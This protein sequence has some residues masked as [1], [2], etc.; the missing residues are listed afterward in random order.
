[1]MTALAHRG[2]DD[3]GFHADERAVLGNRRLEVIDLEGGRQPL[4]NEDESLWI[5][6]NGEIYNY[7][8]LRRDL[9]RAGHRFRTHTD[10]EV[11]LHLYE[12]LGEGCLER[13]RG[14]FAF[15]IWDR[16]RDRLFAARDRFGQKP[17]FYSVVGDRLL[18]ASEIKGLLAAGIAPDPEPA[19]VDYYLTFRFVPP[20][21]TMFRA[22]R[23]LAAGH[24]LTWS[25]G[26]LR[27]E[28]WWNFEYRE[29]RSRSD[30][31]WL[32]E[33]AERI[34]D[35]VAS[36]LVSDVPVGALLS[37]GLDSSLVALLAARAT[38]RPLP[39]FTI[40][41]EVASYDERPFA[42]LVAAHCR[43]DHHSRVVSQE[44]LT[45][46]P[47]LV[48]YLDEP[49][50]P[51]SA[52]FLESARLA[53]EHVKV[54]LGG[55]GGDELFAGFDRYAA[56]RW[57]DW[58]GRLPPP[59]RDGV[60]RP[61][62]DRLPESFTYKGM[63]QRA[64][65]ALDVGAET[66]AARYA[67]MN[68]FFRF[69]RRERAELYGPEL[70]RALNGHDAEEAITAPFAEVASLHTLH[71][72]LRTDIL[73]KL[74][75]HTMMLSDRL[76]MACG[77]ELRSPL[78]DHELAEL[79]AAMPVRLKV[80]R[81][82]SKWALRRIARGRLPDRI[83]ERPK[84]GFMFPVS[85]WLN[86]GTVPALRASLARGSLVTDGWIRQETVDRLFDE[87]LRRRSDHHVRIWMLLSLQA[88]R[89]LHVDGSGE[90]ARLR[91]AAAPPPRE[92]AESRWRTDPS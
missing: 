6:F 62:V 55:D 33:L 26:E 86:T 75:E 46:I 25:Q 82:R 35:A 17:L 16:A 32:A 51:I 73:T 18:F 68:S 36:H 3:E 23:K 92:P 42:D 24:Y 5:T 11:V 76:S 43:S 83:V 78:L 72:M 56:W 14:M 21:L 81:G 7:R 90:E 44:Q 66:G 2:P 60:I 54:A 40:G 89:T 10:T 52:C 53:S 91:Q 20:P 48:R 34:E 28:P 77:L 13:L 69:G 37:G 88:W 79:T 85:H 80:R 30:A 1:M 74:P 29:A 41:S 8:Q 15:A 49:S 38:D 67:R 59:V 22:I 87:H 84:Q 65:W 9:E 61:A 50:D 47:E 39:T 57:L 45:R 64:R 27:V 70:R 71:R 12:D 19:A 63:V 58:F 4:A 31:D